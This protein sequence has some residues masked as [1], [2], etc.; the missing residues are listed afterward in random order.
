LG[1]AA[2]GREFLAHCRKAGIVGVDQRIIEHQRRRS[3]AL[4]KYLRESQPHENGKLLARSV[5]KR[6][7]VLGLARTVQC[8]DRKIILECQL[9]RAEHA[10]K[11]SPETPRD[12]G[13]VSRLCPA[14]DFCKGSFQEP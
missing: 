1:Y 10:L 2:S 5:R 14:L 7:H 3:A 13:K 9:R 6:C 4:R 11:V 8:I 12:R